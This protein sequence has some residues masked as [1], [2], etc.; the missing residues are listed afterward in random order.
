MNPKNLQPN[1]ALELLELPPNLLQ[2]IRNEEDLE[3]LK[4]KVSQQRK[5]L[6]KKYHPDR[7]PRHAEMMKTINAICDF[8]QK[9]KIQRRSQPVFVRYNVRVYTNSATTSGTTSTSYY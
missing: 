4:I 8:F 9:L 3:N 5:V 7:F 2:L 6:A 1:E